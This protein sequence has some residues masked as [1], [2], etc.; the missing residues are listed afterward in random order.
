MV[1]GSVNEDPPYYDDDKGDRPGGITPG[2][3]FLEPFVIN[4]DTPRKPELNDATM[5]ARMPGRYRRSRRG[6]G[7]HPS[8][9]V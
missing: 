3:S 6:I 4:H 9:P 5:V 8:P 1:A 7:D 2:A